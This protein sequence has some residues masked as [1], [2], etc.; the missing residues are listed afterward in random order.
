MQAGRQCHLLASGE[1]TPFV[2]SANVLLK[3]VLNLTKAT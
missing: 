1:W 2:M 3:W